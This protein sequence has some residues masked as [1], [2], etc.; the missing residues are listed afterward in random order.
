MEG[1]GLQTNPARDTRGNVPVKD[2]VETLVLVRGITG[3]TVRV[4]DVLMV[5]LL[6]RLAVLA[7]WTAERRA[8]LNELHVPSQHL[9]SLFKL[10]KGL[11]GVKM[12]L[13]G[14]LPPTP[15]PLLGGLILFSF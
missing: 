2:K 5:G 1:V 14:V 11:L 8:E 15:L 9:L 13:R 6:T 12:A 4:V 3:F 7:T 10:T